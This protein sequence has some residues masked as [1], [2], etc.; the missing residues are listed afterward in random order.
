MHILSLK[1]KI[2]IHRKLCS[3]LYFKAEAQEIDRI[4]EVFSHK[5]WNTNKLKYGIYKSAG[6]NDVRYCAQYDFKD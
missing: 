3:K 2:P 6:K 4:L 5:Y 1:K